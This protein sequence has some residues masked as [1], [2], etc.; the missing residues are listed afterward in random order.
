M[1]NE[2]IKN[3]TKLQEILAILRDKYPRNEGNNEVTMDLIPDLPF[4]S[5]EEYVQFNETL[6]NDE[7]IRKCF[8]K[9]IKSFGG[10]SLQKFISNILTNC[11]TFEVGHKLSW[12]GAKNTIAISNSPF[13]NSIIGVV[14]RTKEPDCTIALI[15]KHIRNWL[16]HSGDKMRYR[17]KKAQALE[18]N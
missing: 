5:V 8:E 12:T 7:T 11:L 6:K 18:R 15:I 2:I 1:R 4:T 14:S 3:I 9:K 13:A 10:D 16:Q 17:L